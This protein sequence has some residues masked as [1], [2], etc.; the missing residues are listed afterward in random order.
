GGASGTGGAG[1][2]A[3]PGTLKGG[4]SNQTITSGGRSRTFI[5]H[6]PTN[7]TGASPLPVIFDFHPLGGTGAGQKSTSGWDKKCD[8]VGCI[9]VFP[10]SFPSDNSWN[11]GYCCEQSQQ[12]PVDDGQFARDMIKWRQANTCDDSK[13]VYASGRSNGGGMAY[14]L[15]C[16]VADVIA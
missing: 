4:D 1:G 6:I 13:R 9:S 15:A 10:N 14:M 5:V 12:L 2:A 3:C 16:K 11:V 8:S 7:Y